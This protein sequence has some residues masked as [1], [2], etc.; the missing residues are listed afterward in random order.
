MSPWE[1]LDPTQQDERELRGRCHEQGAHQGVAAAHQQNTTEPTVGRLPISEI[2][3]FV[4]VYVRTMDAKHSGCGDEA[5]G[6]NRDGAFFN[7]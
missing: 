7:E 5:T 6:E 4:E 1:L 2:G 3:R